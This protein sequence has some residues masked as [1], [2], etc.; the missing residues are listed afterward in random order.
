MYPAV[1]I[2]AVD[3]LIF[4]GSDAYQAFY[5]HPDLG[6]GTVPVDYIKLGFIV[7]FAFVQ[8]NVILQKPVF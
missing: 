1:P 4:L 2:P 5:V 7:I 8:Y 6:S 3:T